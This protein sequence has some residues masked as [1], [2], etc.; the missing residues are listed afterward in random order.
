MKF[1]RLTFRGIA[2]SSDNHQ[3]D[4]DDDLG[5]TD[6]QRSQKSIA[7]GESVGF[8]GETGKAAMYC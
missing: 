4:D 6:R 7:E 5:I 8:L 1:R 3:P 2:A